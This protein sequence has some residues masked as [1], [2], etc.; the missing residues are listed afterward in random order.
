MMKNKILLVILMSAVLVYGFSQEE[1]QLESTEIVEEEWQSEV[2]EIAEEE[3]Q[4]ESIEIAEEEPQV[5]SSDLAQKE[6]QPESNIYFH[7]VGDIEV[8][9]LVE[10]KRSG[11]IP[12]TLIEIDQELLE[13]YYPDGT[14]LHE[15]NAFLV[16]DGNRVILIDTGFGTTLFDNLKELG[17]DP[18]EV[19]A[20]LITHLH[21][22]HFGGLSRD[23]KA[24]FP[25]AKVYVAHEELEYWTKTNANQGAID[26]L[27]PYQ[28]IKFVP[29][30]KLFPGITSIAAFGHTPGH[31]LFMVE[32]EGRKLLIVGDLLHVQ[33]VQ[34]P[35]PEISV[36][37]DTNPVDAAAVRKNVLEYATKGRFPIGGMH[38][39]YPAIG[40]VNADGDG[41]AFIEGK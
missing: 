5:E 18:R 33:K 4:S 35:H 31:T 7:A 16:R 25:K 28:V 37:Y 40:Y 26:A 23:G 10:S 12:T 29:G 17:V 36:T 27:A 20:V 13:S 38:L 2:T 3:P 6:L 22:D 21:G 39:L 1:A 30:L 9:T 19:E 15:N 14:S 8:F 41:Y 32:S 34:F 24:L 11:G